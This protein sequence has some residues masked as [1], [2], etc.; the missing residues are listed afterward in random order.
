MTLN[1]LEE[2]LDICEMWD[3]IDQIK[4]DSFNRMA[5][6]KLGDSEVSILKILGLQSFLAF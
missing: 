1:F 2:I 6:N 4:G 5:I 3:K